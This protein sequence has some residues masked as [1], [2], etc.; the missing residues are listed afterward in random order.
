MRMLYRILTVKEAYTPPKAQ[1]SAQYY[2]ARR[3]AA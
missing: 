1:M 3:K 2:A